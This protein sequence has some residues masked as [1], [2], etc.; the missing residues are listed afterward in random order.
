MAVI[1]SDQPVIR[2]TVETAAVVMR[3]SPSFIRFGSLE[4]FYWT[5]QY[6]ACGN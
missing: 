6:D 1:G 2:E 4:Y 5:Q 3:M